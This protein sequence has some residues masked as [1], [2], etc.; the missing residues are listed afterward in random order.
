MSQQY[1]GITLDAAYIRDEINHRLNKGS[2]GPAT[3]ATLRNLDDRTINM[4]IH[5][6]A[7]DSFW[8][9]FDDLT[10]RTI[11]YLAGSILP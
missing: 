4:I 11:D 7:D 6:V 1:P 2:I 3:G 5:H 8:Q 10:H 9:A